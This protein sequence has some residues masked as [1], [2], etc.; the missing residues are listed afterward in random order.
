[1]KPGKK[2]KHRVINMRRSKISGEDGESVSGESSNISAA[3]SSNASDN[4]VPL[5]LPIPEDRE[6]ELQTPPSS[7]KLSRPQQH[8]VHNLDNLMHSPQ[9]V[10]ET[11]PRPLAREKSKAPERLQNIRPLFEAGPEMED[12]QHISAST[13][14]IRPKPRRY[15]GSWQPPTDEKSFASSSRVG[16]R[17]PQLSAP[18]P[19]AESSPGGIL[20]QAWMMKMAGEIA[21]R[22]EDQKQA[23]GASFWDGR[24]SPLGRQSPPPAYG[25]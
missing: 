12:S 17:S 5:N 23:G 2:R 13:E 9:K 22:M 18:F 7:P 21:R 8:G 3:V 6:I 16:T 20:E 10:D 25:S 14:T 4:G 24:G 1:M 19:Y 11:T 15:F